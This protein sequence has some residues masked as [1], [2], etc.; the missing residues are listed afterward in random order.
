MK[1]QAPAPTGRSFAFG[2]ICLLAALAFLFSKSLRSQQ[3]L[4]ANDGPLGVLESDALSMPEAFTGYWVDLYWLGSNSGTASISVTYGLLWLLGPI[5]FAKF[6]GPLTL[7]LLGASAW[8][9]FRS[10]GLRPG[11]CTV[12]AAAAALNMNFFSNTCWGLG[13]RA[14]TLAC[15]FLALAALSARAVGNRWL[16]ASLAGLAVG[17]GVIEGADNGAIFSLYVAAFVLFQSWVEDGSPGRKMIAATRVILVA[18]FAALIASQ[19]LTNLV[20]LGIKGIAGMQQDTEGREQRWDWATQWSLPKAETSRVLIPGLYGYRMD[21]PEGGNYW[22]TVGQQPGWTPGS[23]GFA[24]YS[25]AGEYAG[26]LVV[27]VAVWALVESLRRNGSAFT[28]HERRL[29]WFWTAAAVVSLLFAWGR[30]APFYRIIYALP[31]FSTIRNPIKFMHPFHLGLMILFGYGLLALSRKYLEATSASAGSLFAQLKTWWSKLRGLDK[32]WVY[33]CLA[34]LALSVI[35][36]LAYS[37]D[38]ASLVRHLTQVGFDPSQAQQIA[39]F[40]AHEVGWFVLFL[41]VSLGLLFV[42]QS[43]ALAAR[44]AKWAAVLLGVVLVVDLARANTAWIIYYDYREKYASNPV[45]DVLKDKPYLHRSMLAPLG[46]GGQQWAVFQQLFM[47]EWLQHHYQFYNIQSLNVAQEPRMPA[48]KQ[49]YLQAVGPNLAR[50]WQL[51]NTRFLFAPA[52]AVPVMNEQLDPAQKRF[53]AH[54]LFEL[55][56]DPGSTSIGVRTNVIGPLALVEF[57]GAL[58]RARLYAQ[59]QV[60]TNDPATLKTL[61]DPAFDPQQLVLV[62]E[63]P[64]P[65]AAPGSSSEAGTVEYL[66]YTPKRIEMRTTATAQAVLLLNDRY[67]G[68]WRVSVDGQPAQLLRCNFITRGVYVPP[69]HHTVVWEFEV[70]PVGFYLTLGSVCL[71]LLLCAFLAVTSRKGGKAKVESANDQRKA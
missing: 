23:S 58:P 4:F 29:V 44:R 61:A 2:L 45:I 38:R 26:V 8:I 1:A 20:G 59:W 48:D 19:V 9:F 63:N 71:G 13:T 62:A 51:T 69:G 57:T 14:L 42:I 41:V 70:R 21:T 56:Q 3:V 36:W 55:Y 64:G 47:V 10:L 27:L 68:N 40:S 28:A 35:G 37:A 12:A 7:L 66:S 15:A 49:A 5:G 52:A 30:Y 31:Y 18:G 67:D 54:T 53:R 22:G 16:T 32:R 6:Y 39:A 34:L 46:G 33:G 65:A 17:M 24:R 50:Y 11:L 43:G 25:G 60:S